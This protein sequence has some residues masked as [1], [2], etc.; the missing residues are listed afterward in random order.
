MYD[1]PAWHFRES[2]AGTDGQL[3]DSAGSLRCRQDRE[4]RKISQEMHPDN[5]LLQC[6]LGSHEL[7]LCF[8]EMVVLRVEESL[9]LSTEPTSR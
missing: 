7:R 8:Y 4:T 3:K 1:E 2:E 6:K 9:T 5:R